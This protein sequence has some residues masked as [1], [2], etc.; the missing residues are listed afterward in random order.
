[1][2]L[3]TTRCHVCEGEMRLRTLAPTEGEEHG[4]RMQIDGMPVMEC[5]QGHKRFVAP[6]FAVKLM[7]AL[8]K[9]SQLVPV[10]PATQRGMLRKRYCCPECS[11]ELQDSANPIEARRVL[12]LSGLDAFGVRVEMP[13]LRCSACGRDYVPPGD[14]VFGNLMQA[15]A[16]AFR[17]AA[18]SAT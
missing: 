15:S 8:V 16:H 1:M 12:E 10:G 5:A 17:A 4:V 11:Q 2:K 3:N 7:E 18:V 14:V 13:K 6:D 9:D